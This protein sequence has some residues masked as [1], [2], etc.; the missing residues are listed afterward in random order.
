MPNKHW[1]IAIIIMFLAILIP[2]Y[3]YGADTW[4]DNDLIMVIESLPSYVDNDD[5]TLQI[6]S[7]VVYTY[8]P[9]PDITIYELSLIIPIFFGGSSL[10]VDGL[11]PEARR[12]FRK[13][14]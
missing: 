2:Y 8:E 6:Y 14:N 4:D 10:Y 5:L 11:P 13:D 9:K 7:E 12:H 3:V 1:L